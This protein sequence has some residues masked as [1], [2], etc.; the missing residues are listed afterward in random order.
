MNISEKNIQ[1]FK[2]FGLMSEKAP[3][4]LLNTHN[5]NQTMPDKVTIPF[6]FQQ[7][8]IVNWV[9]SDSI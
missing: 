6:H 8:T 5:N 4:S 9:W 2:E 3:C 1:K 7:D